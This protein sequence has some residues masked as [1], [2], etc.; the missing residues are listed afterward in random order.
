M[1]KEELKL[2]ISR[3]VQLGEDSVELNFWLEIYD[4]LDESQKAELDKNL[5][6]ELLN[7][8]AGL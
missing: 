5:H 8:Q 2:L 6:K 1:R 3:L 7:L 4:S